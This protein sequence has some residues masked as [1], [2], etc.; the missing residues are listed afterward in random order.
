MK[1]SPYLKQ[2]L[3]FLFFF[4]IAYFAKD[5]LMPLAIGGVLATLFLPLCK[6]LEKKN[7]NKALASSICLLLLAMMVVSIIGILSWGIAEFITDYTLVK[8]K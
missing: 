2:F 3:G 5:F 7:I 1:T 8:Q 4:A 6:W